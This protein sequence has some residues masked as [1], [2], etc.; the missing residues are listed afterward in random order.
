MRQNELTARSE[1]VHWSMFHFFSFRWKGE[2]CFARLSN[3]GEGGA[4]TNRWKHVYTYDLFRSPRIE[5]T[6]SPSVWCLFTRSLAT[7]HTKLRT[8]WHLL[9]H[10]HKHKHNHW[11][12]RTLLLILYDHQS[13]HIPQIHSHQH[14]GHAFTHWAR[15]DVSNE[16]MWRCFF[17]FWMKTRKDKWE[18]FRLSR[19]IT[20]N[21]F[22]HQP[23]IVDP[24][25][26]P[27][28]HTHTKMTM[29]MIMGGPREKKRE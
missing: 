5:S 4:H 20:C 10:T 16:Q 26:H 6:L 19:R 25:C 7:A 29:V 28:N 18:N 27:N 2:M 12:T 17:I 1:S 14:F 3:D 15:I 13:P 23:I 8:H 21:F 9:K 22:F 11:E 24:F